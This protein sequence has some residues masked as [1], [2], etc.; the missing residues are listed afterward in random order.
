MH[1]KDRIGYIYKVT[2]PNGKIY[3]GQ[4]INL[5][6]RRSAYRTNNFKKQI[7]L[8]RNCQTYNWNPLD[9]LEI[10]EECICENDKTVLNE[11][12]IYWIKELRAFGPKGLNCT[13][14]GEGHIG[15]HPSIETRKKMSLA[16]LGRKFSEERNK[17]LSN[18]RKTFK[19]S[20]ESKEKM[21]KSKLGKQATEETKEKM[22][23]TRTGKIPSVS[24]KNNVIVSIEKRCNKQVVVYGITYN[25]IKE[26]V[27]KTKLSRHMIN[28]ITNMP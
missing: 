16:G 6:H 26:A 3:V 25:S 5:K 9:T 11:R 7:K 8:W 15:L 28:K 24:H 1:V 23:I 22:S 13:K 14:G 19:Y 4:T 21:S 20:K 10:I 27:E 12:E 18:F 17:K 2:S